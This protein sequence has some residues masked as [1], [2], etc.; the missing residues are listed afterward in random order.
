MQQHHPLKKK[1]NYTIFSAPP[2][3]ARS[4]LLL[5]VALLG[6]PPKIPL[7]RVLPLS[8]VPLRPSGASRSVLIEL[9]VATA[10]SRS[11]WSRARF[12]AAGSLR[13]S[14][15]SPKSGMF[16]S[17]CRAR[18]S[19]RR[20]R[21]S[22]LVGEKDEWDGISRR[23]ALAVMLSARGRVAVCVVVGGKGPESGWWAPSLYEGG[24]TGT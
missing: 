5:L 13:P 23:E 16:L 6:R 8:I 17:N 3:L 24:L 12:T 20:R 1:K 9:P 18:L 21:T 14:N 2:S 19:A 10:S 11:A 7:L 15:T 4:S 22:G